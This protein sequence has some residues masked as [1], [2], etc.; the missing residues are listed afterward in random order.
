MHFMVNKTLNNYNYYIIFCI[1]SLELMIP[2][3]V[4]TKYLFILQYFVFVLRG[5]LILKPK[6]YV[7]NSHQC[8]ILYIFMIIIIDA[9]KSMAIVILLLSFWS[10]DSWKYTCKLIC[11]Y[12]KSV[13]KYWKKTISTFVF[14]IICKPRNQYF[15]KLCTIMSLFLLCNFST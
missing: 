14:N 9:F 15:I 2:W 13:T 5:G 4:K 10:V 1:W 7:F 6:M 11:C 8:L 3:I 12:C